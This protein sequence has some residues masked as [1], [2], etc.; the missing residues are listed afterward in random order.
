MRLVKCFLFMYPTKDYIESLA[1]RKCNR[2]TLITR[3]NKIID[4]RYRKKNYLVY[5][6]L[7]GMEDNP[8]KPD[9]SMLDTRIKILKK[10][11]IIS[12]GI[13]FNDFWERLKRG[14]YP[15]PEQILSQIEEISELVLGGFHQDC[16]V[17]EVASYVYRKGIK[18]SVDEDTTDQFF[19]LFDL[20]GLPPV[21]R[22]Q[23]QYAASL[24]KTFQEGK[25]GIPNWMGGLAIENQRAD[26]KNQPWLVQI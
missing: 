10:D 11:R 24:L 9:T 15:D 6:L 20:S 1:Q 22:T 23:E 14:I 2:R 4:A 19:I 17:K 16:C 25:N 26:R 3:F 12:A 7:F 13:S 18:I 5:W 21:I 8:E